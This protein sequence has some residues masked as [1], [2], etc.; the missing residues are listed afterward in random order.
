MYHKSEKRL[1]L[2]ATVPFFLLFQVQ[3]EFEN[4]EAITEDR[5]NVESSTNAAQLNAF[6]FNATSSNLL[7]AAVI[8][9]KLID[10]SVHQ[11]IYRL[12]LSKARRRLRFYPLR[13]LFFVSSFFARMGFLHS[14]KLFSCLNYSIKPNRLQQQ[15]VPI[16]RHL[17]RFFCTKKAVSERTALTINN[18]Q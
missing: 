5:S 6:A 15:C 4:Y 12:T 7:P 10:T 13:I 11:R 16:K 14:A 2:N 9:D 17:K 1:P 8:A 18:Y 3:N